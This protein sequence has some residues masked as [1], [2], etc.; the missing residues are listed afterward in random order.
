MRRS[1]KNASEYLAEALSIEVVF[2]PNS[3]A[4][5]AMFTTLGTSIRE[6]R[7]AANTA[8]AMIEAHQFTFHGLAVLLGKAQHGVNLLSTAIASYDG[9]TRCSPVHQAD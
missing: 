7:D 5:A 3:S 9:L 8:L 6:A 2:E 4:P 1:L